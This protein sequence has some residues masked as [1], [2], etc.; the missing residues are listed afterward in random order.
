M[1]PTLHLAAILALALP[2]IAH[3]QITGIPSDRNPSGSVLRVYE[4]PYYTLHTDLPEADAREADLR[5]TRMFEEYQRRTSGFAGQV[6]KKFPFFL[7][8]NKADFLAAGAPK[9]SAGVYIEYHGS[10][11]LMAVAGEKTTAETW[12]VVQHEGFHQF[13]R[14]AIQ[15]DIP[16]WANE[17]LA[18]YFGE[19]LWTGDGFVTGLIPPDR[20]DDVKTAI[21]NRTFRPFFQ[22]MNM[23]DEEWGNKLEYSNYDQAW[24]M[25]HFLAHAENGRYQQPFLNFMNQ[26]SHGIPPTTAWSNI[27]GND[28]AAFERRFAEYW[29]GLPD[30]PSRP[31]YMKALVQ[32]ET[33][34]LARA[35]I[36]R[37]T[38]PDPAAFF[39]TYNPTTIAATNRDLWLPPKLFTDATTAALKV[40]DWTFE[41][42][43]GAPKLVCKDEDGTKFV[44]TFS[45][46]NGKVGRV[47]VDLLKPAATAN[48]NTRGTPAPA[49]RG[50][51]RT[52]PSR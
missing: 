38:F 36:Q 2:T 23:T 31:E 51:Q 19:G 47:S 46:G 21:K 24:A 3:A 44:G 22:M 30:N 34:F 4:T 26:V 20:L 48:N 45:V 42:G 29:M 35:T 16:I 33:S 1:R 37:Q 6:N 52:A 8:K 15:N 43:N 13:I 12:H 32:T 9:G 49:G 14:A 18:E 25:V 5:M 11:W 50:I 17:G 28:S 7:Y 41:T 27:F 40:G 10:S 39:R